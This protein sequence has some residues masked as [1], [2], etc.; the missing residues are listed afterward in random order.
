MAGKLVSRVGV[1]IDEIDR[2]IVTN[3]EAAVTA[4]D[5][6]ESFEAKRTISFEN[7]NT[8]FRSMP[9]T[10]SPFLST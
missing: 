8:F 1:S 4:A 5:R 10:V 2:E 6:G 9:R 7:W 3:C